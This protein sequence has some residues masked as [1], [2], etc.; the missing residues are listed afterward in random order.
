[1]G[2]AEYSLNLSTTRYRGG[3]TTYLEVITAQGLALSDERTAVHTPGRR[4]VASVLLVKAL[5]GGWN[6]SDLQARN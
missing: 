6:A 5:G 2:A 1:M 3:V 4:M